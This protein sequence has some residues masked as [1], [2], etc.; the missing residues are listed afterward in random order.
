VREKITNVFS[1]DGLV[2]KRLEDA[3]VDARL[4]ALVKARPICLA[5]GAS[6]NL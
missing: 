2:G 3:A 1:E 4:C 6:A 5:S